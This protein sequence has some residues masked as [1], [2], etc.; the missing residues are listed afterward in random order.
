MFHCWF[1]KS[2]ISF[3]S[4]WL[5]PLEPSLEVALVVLLSTD[6]QVSSVYATGRRNF[7]RGLY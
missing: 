4:I 1:F 2:T 6:N 7:R 5:C 3:I